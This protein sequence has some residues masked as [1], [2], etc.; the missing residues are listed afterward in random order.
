VK[1]RHVT[2]R[3]LAAL[4]DT[5]VVFVQGAR[6]SGKTTLVQSL[7]KISTPSLSAHYGGWR[8]T[9]DRDNREKGHNHENHTQTKPHRHRPRFSSGL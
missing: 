9:S 3:V 4:A 5:P 7:A 8:G 6:Q 1:R 2:R